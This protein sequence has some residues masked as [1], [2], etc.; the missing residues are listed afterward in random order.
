M[1][2]PLANAAASRPTYPEFGLWKTSVSGR[3]SS[4]G[5]ANGGG[6]GGGSRAR[7]LG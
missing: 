3:Q 1:L 5:P 6:G 7:L 2:L 4:A